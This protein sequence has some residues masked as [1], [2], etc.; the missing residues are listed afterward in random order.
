MVRKARLPKAELLRFVVSPEGVLTFDVVSTLPGH[1]LWL[2]ADADVVEAG[3]KRGMVS[4]AAR[5]RVSIPDDLA[6]RIVLALRQRVGD[7]IG[8]ARRSGAAVSG[9]EKAREWLN[10]RKCGILVEAADGSP[11][12]RAR[13]LGGRDIKVVT[14]LDAE[15]LGAI[16]GRERAVHVAIAPGRLAA[17]IEQEAARLAGVAR[18]LQSGQR[19]VAK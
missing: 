9:F 17:M 4:R 15:A 10:S 16:F 8:L 1:G 11:D 14:P 12:E 13:L 6:I 2:S 19:D 7:L 5:T 18:L 3:L